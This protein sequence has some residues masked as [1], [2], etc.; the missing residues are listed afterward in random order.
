MKVDQ[1]TGE[2][3]LTAHEYQELLYLGNIPAS[4]ELEK[5]SQEWYKENYEGG[6]PQGR[7]VVIGAFKDGANWQKQQIKSPHNYPSY[8]DGYNIGLKDGKADLIKYS[9]PGYID[10]DGENTWARSE[11]FCWLKASITKDFNIGQK[12]KLLIIPSEDK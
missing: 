3:T 11:N 8:L 1:R 9:A 6:N 4:D 7:A 5:A 12:V 10:S 2:V